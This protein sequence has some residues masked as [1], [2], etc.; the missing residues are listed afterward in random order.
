MQEKKLV[1]IV[2][3]Y[4]HASFFPFIFLDF[5]MINIAYFLS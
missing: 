1:S 4:Q 2:D 5:K 3:M